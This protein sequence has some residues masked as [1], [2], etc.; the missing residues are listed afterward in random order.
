M[1]MRAL[2]LL[3]LFTGVAGADAPK[4]W[5]IYSWFDLACSATPQAKSAPN[6]DSVCF[7]LLPATKQ[8][9]TADEIK[10]TPLKLA[11]I[12]RALVA[13]PKTAAVTWMLGEVPT[14]DRFDLPDAGGVRRTLAD[15]VRRLGLSL[16]ITARP[17][18][19]GTVTMAADGSLDLALRSLPPGPIAEAL[20]HYAT[21]D[22]HHRATL[23][24][25]GGLKRGETK[26]LPP[27]PQ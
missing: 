16:A 5:E 25:V 8:L 10:R 1:I 6:A 14:S 3:L 7:A 18:T 15:E 27:F 4:G 22:P 11:D 21:S 26:L 2:G 24:H 17:A 19:V 9:K 13:V 20:V 12:E 23:D